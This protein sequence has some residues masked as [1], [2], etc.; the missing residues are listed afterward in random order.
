MNDNDIGP[1]L[2]R[3]AAALDRIAPD[4]NNSSDLSTA[5]AF[6]WHAS[7]NRYWRLA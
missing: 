5:D 3:I 6:V 4:Q 2:N 7:N 1:L